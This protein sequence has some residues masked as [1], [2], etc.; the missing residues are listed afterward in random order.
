MKR[1]LGGLLAAALS[2]AAPAHAQFRNVGPGVADRT[3]TV[4][5]SDGEDN[6]LLGGEV[7]TNLE[8]DINGRRRQTRAYRDLF[9]ESLLNAYVLAPHG[10]SLNIVGRFEP[11]ARDPDGRN[12][13]FA[14]QA[15][16]LDEANITWTRGPLDLFGG[17]IHPR[18]GSAWDRGPGLFG[19]DF[20]RRYELTEKLGFGARIWWSDL[21]GLT[22][23]FGTHNV[24]FEAFQND[25][26]SLSN[27]AFTRRFAFTQQR[28]DP[29]TGDLVDVPRLSFRNTRL[30]G[31]PD[32][33]GG[34][35]GQVLSFAGFGIPMP[36]GLA[37]Y[38]ISLSNRQPGSDA[39]AAGRAAPERGISVGAFWT[40][41]LPFRLTAAPFVEWVRQEGADGYSGRSRDWLTAGADIRR[42]P[43]TLSLAYLASWERD[44]V[45]GRQTRDQPTASLSYDLNFLAP[46]PILRATTVTVGWRRLREDRVATNDFGAAVSWAYKF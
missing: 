22:R 11:A 28:L 5:R 29:A 10:F 18:F 32:N 9:N 3:G 21:V 35:P 16:W 27:G 41:P 38:T 46:M 17:K 20:G 25:T 39:I 6:W 42:A 26:T 43:W 37:G 24:Q 15:A 8:L 33:R 45:A 40:V 23:R 44:R 31:G 34:L 7:Q 30:A 4:A 13:F 1:L 19:T 2:A 12:R 14:T 36:R